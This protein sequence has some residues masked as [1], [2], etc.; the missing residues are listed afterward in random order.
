M[1]E[2]IINYRF[3]IFLSICAV[4]AVCGWLYETIR[5]YPLPKRQEDPEPPQLPD[6]RT[7]AEWFASTDEGGND[8]SP[9]N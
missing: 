1:I 2:L 4:A 7:L 3:L 6:K 9:G 5:P 8:K